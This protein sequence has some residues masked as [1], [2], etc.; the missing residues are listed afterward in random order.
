MRSSVPSE[1][2]LPPEA[3]AHPSTTLWLIRHAEVE[4]KYQGVFGGQIDMDLSRRGEEQAR[5]LAKYLRSVRVDTLYASP[6]KRVQQTLAP[7]LANGLVEPTILPDLREVHFGDWTGMSWE[8][9][10]ERFGISAYAWLD[11]L[12]CAGIRNA[13]SS[14]TLRA[15]VEPCLNQIL[16]AD[17]GKQVAVACHGGVIRML[18]S[19]ILELPLPKMALF[20]IDYASVTRIVW[21]NDRSPEVQLLNFTPWSVGNG[22]GPA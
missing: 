5:A 2:S 19:I 16:G 9:V 1:Q 12:E 17:R 8:E 10:L 21:D 3:V 7:A 15:R 18:L 14:A 13:E 6:M 20:Q 4:P 22:A 11:Q